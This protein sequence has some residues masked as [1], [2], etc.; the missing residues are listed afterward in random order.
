MR[1]ILFLLTVCLGFA[2]TSFG[3]GT[4]KGRIIDSTNKQPLSLATVTIFKAADTTIITY[5]LS[6]P[7]GNFKVP[8]IPYDVNCRM[9]ISFSGFGVYRKEFTISQGEGTKE[10]GDI[11]MMPDA[12]S[13]DEVLVIAERP[14]VVVKKDT[15][16]FNAS[17]FKT[18]P[19][20]LV[21]DLLKK[22]PGVMV[23]KDGNINVNG[24]SVNRILVD[25]KTFFGDD[26]KMATRNLPANVIDKV[27][28]TD[29]KDELLRNGDD[30]INNVGKVINITLKKGV[31]KGWFGKLYAGGGTDELYEAGGIANIYR[32]T[33]QL[34][35]LGYMNN[36]NKPGFSFSELM[37]AGGMQRNQGAS[38]GTS[39][40]INNSSSGSS[41][42]S[43][44]GVNFGGGQGGG[45]ATS[46]GVGFNLNH[47]P[48]TKKTFFL[49]YFYGNVHNNR[50]SETETQQYNGD[51]VISN[52]TALR[53]L[54]ITNAH[55]IGAGARLK[56]DSVTNILINANYTLGLSNENRA[57][58]I[59]STNN[60]LGD[61]SSG[62]VAQRNLSDNHY[63]RH[64]IS[65]TRLSKTKKGRRFTINHN[66]DINNRYNDYTTN[67]GLD[68]FYP[69]PYDSLAAQLRNERIPRTDASVAFN[70]SEPLSKIM[71]VRMG[72]RYEYGKITNDVNTFS[73][74]PNN[75]APDTP[76]PLRTSSFDRNSNRILLT[77]GLEFKWKN[78]TVTPSA[79]A[80]FQYV[81]NDLASMPTTL[82]QKSTDI[83]PALGIVFKQLNFNYNRDVSLPSYTYLLP[84]SD[85]TNPY[86][87]TRGNTALEPARRDNLS[88]NYY[89]NDPKRY[90]NVN[91][92]GSGSF[93]KNDVVQSISVDDKGVQTTM[94][95]NADGTK[96]FY[97]NYNI[98]K[99]YK[100]KQKFTFTWN[101]GAYYSYNRNQLLYN[102]EVSWQTTWQLNQWAGIGLNWNDKI[103]WNSNG[104]IGHNFT[105]YSSTRF[106]KL[107]VNTRYWDNELIVRWP[108]HVIWE[109]QCSY[110]FNS[111]A[112][113]GVP[114][115]VVRWNAAVNF[116]MLRDEVGVL[117]LSV[118]DILNQNQNASAYVNR[119][120]ITT[121]FT[122]TLTQYFMATFTY[123]VRAAGTKKSVGGRERFFLF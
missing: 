69:T 108:K 70:Y 76:D 121:N 15:I 96:N 72:G 86:Y 75:Q 84:V 61:L 3:Q 67:T 36:L 52:K 80:L 24:K 81:N 37:Q 38:N 10:V 79:R 102:G 23:D 6:D 30:N 44:N 35:V 83:L 95:V 45:V 92:Y 17:A 60:L 106:N 88:V 82:K 39:I 94:P 59:N 14:P 104:S 5:R 16:E 98:Y 100:N 58:L 65:V 2:G 29:D 33:L 77:P 89:F 119:N 91:F 40:N 49:Q 73:K 66:L 53:G 68:F 51:T 21:E 48:N 112:P 117:R 107:K 22:L 55:N 110:A 103:E 56:P 114:K 64:S 28:V 32:D 8:G 99:Q 46:K 27:Q 115:D 11:Y 4:L 123:N 54:T 1:K 57:S 31:K 120:M 20:A 74:D 50:I 18:L 13:L 7:E 109:T 9:V 118:F 90:I 42:V 85:N 71:T 113:T 41:S 47:A 63:Y 111:N 116:T 122:N 93:T 43:I 105:Q 87:I 34:S 97:V 78:F 19:N 12:K 62:D 25:G 26:P 101:T